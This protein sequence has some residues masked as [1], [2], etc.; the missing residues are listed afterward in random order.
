LTGTGVSWSAWSFDPRVSGLGVLSG[1]DQ[2]Y[3]E[4]SGPVNR[5]PPVMVV[6]IIEP[7]RSQ[8]VAELT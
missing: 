5:H 3:V 2:S 4:R 7:R 1:V 6:L 8:Q